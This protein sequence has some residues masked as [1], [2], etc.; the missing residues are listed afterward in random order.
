MPYSCPLLDNVIEMNNYPIKQIDEM[1]KKTENRSWYYG[2][3]DMLVMLNIPYNSD[4]AIS[5]AEEV[6]EFIRDEGRK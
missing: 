3:A 1:T 6:M 2:L 4:K 5:L